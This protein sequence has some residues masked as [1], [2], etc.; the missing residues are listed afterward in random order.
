MAGGGVAM[1]VRGSRWARGGPLRRATLRPCRS[2]SRCLKT[3]RRPLLSRWRGVVTV[4]VERRIKVDQVNPFGVHAARDV[5]VVARPH[6][7]VLPVGVGHG[8]LQ[9]LTHFVTLLVFLENFQTPLKLSQR[10]LSSHHGVEHSDPQIDLIIL[11]HGQDDE[12][13]HTNF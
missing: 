13:E 8:R 10:P 6:R 2:V 1:Q 9:L 4:G 12:N 11:L 5:Q 3:P 7:A